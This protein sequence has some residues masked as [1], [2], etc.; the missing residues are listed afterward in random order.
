M[1]GLHALT[2]I[3]VIIGGLNWLLVGVFKWDIGVIF[4]G[5]DAWVS[6]IIYI[7][8]GLSAF[9]EIFAHPK[10]NKPAGPAPMQ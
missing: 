9:Y 7:L 4:G 8:V 5:Q 3:L 6:R 1:K 2:W 10:E